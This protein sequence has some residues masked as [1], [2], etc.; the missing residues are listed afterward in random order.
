MGLFSLLDQAVFAISCSS[1]YVSGHASVDDLIL[2]SSFKVLPVRSWIE[3]NTGVLVDFHI[4]KRKNQ[5]KDQ[6]EDSFFS[7]E[8]VITWEIKRGNKMTSPC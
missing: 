8:M 1:A 3:I 6:G 5:V 7:L 4:F 2:C